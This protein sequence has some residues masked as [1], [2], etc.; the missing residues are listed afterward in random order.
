MRIEIV[1]GSVHNSTSST[2]Q[3]PASYGIAANGPGA[4]E[5]GRRCGD[6]HSGKPQTISVATARR[7]HAA[8]RAPLGFHR[9]AP[10]AAA[11]SPPASAR[12]PAGTEVVRPLAAATEK[13]V[14]VAQSPTSAR[15][16]S[17]AAWPVG[18]GSP[19]GAAVPGPASVRPPAAT[20]EAQSPWAMDG[21]RVAEG[22]LCR[23]GRL[24]AAGPAGRGPPAGSAVPLT[25]APGRGLSSPVDPKVAAFPEASPALSAARRPVK[26]ATAAFAGAELR[27][28]TALHRHGGPHQ[29]IGCAAAQAPPASEASSADRCRQPGGHRGADRAR[30]ASRSCGPG[31]GRLVAG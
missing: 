24:R 16:R 22:S 14:H 6:P 18:C 30:A 9:K 12:T 28:V 20:R 11:V 23:R 26:G 31:A 27:S 7:A 8:W 13:R 21:N 1:A 5:R 15:D 17:R 3:W 25:A 29:N 10:R 2:M 4:E 19:A